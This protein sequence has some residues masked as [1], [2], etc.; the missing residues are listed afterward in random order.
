MDGYGSDDIAADKSRN[1]TSF[2][3]ESIKLFASTVHSPNAIEAK[4]LAQLSEDTS[5]RLRELI[6]SSFQ[7]TRHSKR[8]KLT[9]D[10]VNRALKASDSQAIYGFSGSESSKEIHV[11]E[12]GVF[13]TEDK[14]VDLVKISESIINKSYKVNLI[15]ESPQYRIDWLNPGSRT[16][17]E[18]NQPG[19]DEKP[20][21][22]YLQLMKIFNCISKGIISRNISVFHK[23]L[24]GLSKHSNVQHIL[25]YLVK[26][27]ANNVAKTNNGKTARQLLLSIRALSKNN[28]LQVTSD[29]YV[30]PLVKSVLH[31]ILRGSSDHSYPSSSSS[32]SSATST[33]ASVLTSSSVPPTPTLN[34]TIEDNNNCS[35][36]SD[37]WSLKSFASS[38]LVDMFKEWSSSFVHNKFYNHII[39]ALVSCICDSSQSYASHYGAIVAFTRLGFDCIINHLYPFIGSYLNEL[40][41]YQN[42]N[43]ISTSHDAIGAQ[44]I[45]GAWLNLAA[46][47]LRKFREM[48]LVENNFQ[49]QHIVGEL[50]EH[51]GDS[52]AMQLPADFPDPEK[53]YIKK[54][55]QQIKMPIVTGEELLDTF[56]DNNIGGR[57]GETLSEDEELRSND[58]IDGKSNESEKDFKRHDGTHLLVESTISD[59]SLG[60]KLTI[61]KIRRQ[62]R[63]VD[64]QYSSNGKSGR[65]WKKPKLQNFME[66]FTEECEDLL[67]E[68][69][70][71]KGNLYSH[72]MVKKTLSLPYQPTSWYL[73]LASLQTLSE[74]VT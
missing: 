16:I 72:R 43:L 19:P 6:A 8:F 26:F 71:T 38:I 62:R 41:I 51:F 48:A 25:S 31:C 74:S 53:I 49:F 63:S 30:T 47:L 14:P 65:K 69:V 36:S 66:C 40:S 18:L 22:E 23:T 67:L 52:L 42:D 11:P 59:P 34:G 44:Q 4:V 39:R 45:L 32:S 73:L 33:L 28:Y 1:Y 46:F 60:V 50:L 56:Y 55:P 29:I 64:E 9:C 17:K 68:K 7:Y 61:K 57:G 12:A 5:Y 70:Q 54:P 20:S 37:T 21:P 24:V 35:D 27:I 10:D 13:V 2:G 58:S 15:A 3:L